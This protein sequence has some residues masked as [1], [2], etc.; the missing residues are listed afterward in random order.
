MVVV[1]LGASAADALT[2]AG[3]RIPDV[4]DKILWARSGASALGAPGVPHPTTPAI[5]QTSSHDFDI[6]EGRGYRI[7]DPP[8]PLPAPRFPA[9]PQDGSIRPPTV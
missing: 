5:P 7:Q 9:P 8:R 1:R 3:P 6:G 4:S 2:V